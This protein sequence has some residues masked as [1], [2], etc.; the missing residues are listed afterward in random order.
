MQSK[1]KS[2]LLERARAIGADDV[3]VTAATLPTEHTD[4]LRQWLDAGRH[5]EMDYMARSGEKRASAETVLPGA[6]SVIIFAFGYGQQKAMPVYSVDEVGSAKVRV[7]KY[8][9]G[10][11]Y[12]LVLRQR[13]EPVVE[14]LSTELPGNQW[15]VCVDSAPLLERAFAVEAGIGFWGKNTMVLSPRAGSFFFLAEIVTTAEIAPDPPITG[16]CGN[17][18]RCID[19]C[20][21]AAIV[22]PY[23]L[24]ARKCISY[25]TI[26]KKSELTAEES[27]QLH[28]WAF[29]CDICQDVCPYNK[30]TNPTPVAEFEEGRIVHA[31]ESVETFGEP[32]SNSAFER[33]FAKSPIL[34]PGR[35]RVQRN[36]R[37]AARKRG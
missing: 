32:A 34:R 9:L 25:L 31:S 17:C 10:E 33:R 7:A 15:R 18:T 6:K 1:L 36:A 11:D 26:E 23:E 19:A 3:R 30:F 2:Q 16:T 29:G 13:L 37:L 4:R 14:W 27:S 24:D 22:A 28:G 35:R 12:H 8:A 21:T 5:G 20:P